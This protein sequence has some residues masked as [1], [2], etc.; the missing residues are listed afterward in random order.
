VATRLSET[1]YEDA[2][3]LARTYAE[4]S[5]SAVRAAKKLANHLLYA[6]AADQFAEERRLIHGL[7]GGAD[8]AES[9]RAHFEQRAPV[10]E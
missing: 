1:P 10:F 3:A 5:P 8:Q 9:V 2:F 7:A 4:R 6:R